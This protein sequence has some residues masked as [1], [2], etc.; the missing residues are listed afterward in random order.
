M[1]VCWKCLAAEMLCAGWGEGRGGGLF[2][3]GELGCLIWQ[4]ENGRRRGGLSTHGEVLRLFTAV[5]HMTC[6]RT[7]MW[8]MVTCD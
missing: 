3:S 1:R 4:H 5:G 6:T 7:K 2:W 8:T